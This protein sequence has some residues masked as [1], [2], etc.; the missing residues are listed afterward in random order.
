MKR[1]NCVILGLGLMLA[2]TS[3]WACAASQ[4]VEF[5]VAPRYNPHP[6]G[7]FPLR[8]SNAFYQPFINEEQFRWV[9]EAGFN[10]VGQALK[11][12][13][14]IDSCLVL[15]AR[16]DIY[17]S[18][19]PWDATS[20]EKLPAIIERYSRNPYVWG[21]RGKDE[22]SASQFPHLAKIQ[23]LYDS[24]APW[25][26]PFFNL[27]PAM[28]PEQLGDPDYRAYVEEFVCTVN[29]AYISYDCYPI[30]VSKKGKVNIWENYYLTLETVADVARRSGRPF[31]AYILCNKHWSYPKPSPAYLRFQIYT[32][33]AYGA[34]A[35][36][37]FT[38]LLP[39]F[40]RGI[41]DFTD[42]PIDSLGRRTDVWYMVR[43][44][45]REII[46]LTEVF[47]GAEVSDVSHVGGKLPK[48]THRMDVPL[49]QP[50][51]KLAPKG[52]GVVASQIANG[53]R[54]YLVLVNKDVVKAQKV[55]LKV[56]GQVERIFPDGTKAQYAGPDFT[57]Q[58]GNAAIFRY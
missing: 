43:D 22:P 54:R 34:Q 30:T 49:P 31:W 17:V 20:L 35:L 29:P 56:K 57:L 36:S 3:L 50:F 38:Y 8:A 11:E 13:A 18:V 40:D 15:A 6:Q 37:Y 55:V 39:D 2:L 10:T 21:F 44:A 42:S 14:E 24:L 19:S 23:E 47:L 26:S 41:G 53:D 1:R 12:E 28:G 7:V 25:Q 51:V 48:G 52:A 32:N 16:N 5:P 46:N 4:P 9:K 33:L 45:N 58:P 27:L